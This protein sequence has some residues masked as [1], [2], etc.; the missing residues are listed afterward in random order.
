[1]DS[2][3]QPF[4]RSLYQ[5]YSLH[6]Y[7]GTMV[8]IRGEKWLEDACSVYPTRLRPANIDVD[9][10]WHKHNE[11]LVKGVQGGYTKGDP[12]V[13]LDPLGKTRSSETLA[14][15]F[16]DW[17]EQGGSRLVFVIKAVISDA[18][19]LLIDLHHSLM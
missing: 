12:V 1:M 17:I 16:F 3:Y 18:Q 11:G 6:G 7:V 19:N 8:P 10:H 13:L 9:T 4:S 2:I 15:D 14:T 5:V